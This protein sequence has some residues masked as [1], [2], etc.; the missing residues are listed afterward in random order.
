MTTQHDYDAARELVRQHEQAN[1]TEF[2]EKLRGL[3]A[4]YDGTPGAGDAARAVA[5]RSGVY[6]HVDAPQVEIQAPGAQLLAAMQ[7]R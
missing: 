1:L 4:A 2:R 7:R 3:C 5:M 6:M